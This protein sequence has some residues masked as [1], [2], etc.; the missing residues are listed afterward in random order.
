MDIWHDRAVFHF[1]TTAEDRARYK[2]HPLDTLRPGGAAIVATFAPGGPDKCSGPPVQRYSPEQLPAELGPIFELR[3][4]RA[5]VH[6][7]SW[8]STQSFQYSRPQ[9]RDSMSNG[10][11]LSQI[12][13][14]VPAGARGSGAVHG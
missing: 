12:A 11:W 9:R 13:P 2:R 5:H 3:D 10:T 7:T 1:L 4:A 6:S 14:R 8:G